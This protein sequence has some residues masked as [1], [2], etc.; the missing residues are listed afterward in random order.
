MRGWRLNFNFE[1]EGDVM[2]FEIEGRDADIRQAL[3]MA[4][5]IMGGNAAKSF[6]G[7]DPPAGL[8]EDLDILSAIQSGGPIKKYEGKFLQIAPVKDLSGLRSAMRVE[9][10]D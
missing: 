5:I 8:I 9:Y 2:S 4:A 1:D 6:A 7:A 10:K 3:A